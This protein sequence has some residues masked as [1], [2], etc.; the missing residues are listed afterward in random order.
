MLA[1]FDVAVCCSDFEGSP[2]SV[3]E[4]MEAGKPVVATRVGGLPEL[5]EDGVHGRLIEPRNPEA[6][7]TAV[8]E[9]LED[10]SL[11]AE[12]GDRAR[13]RRRQEF[14]IDTLVSRLEGLY[15]DLYAAKSRPAEAQRV[16]LPSG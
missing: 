8:S 6:L 9:L 5:I 11:A 16:P 2:L 1:S 4:Y 7:A 14:C 10:R 15:E 13:E 3:M 12:M